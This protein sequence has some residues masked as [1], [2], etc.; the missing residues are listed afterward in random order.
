MGGQ[1]AA[2]LRANPADAQI[3][4]LD[5]TAVVL[6]RLTELFDH[7]NSTLFNAVVPPESVKKTV[8]V[9]QPPPVP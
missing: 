7:E 9:T 4:A 8:R 6:A 5:E 3:L 2:D 1:H